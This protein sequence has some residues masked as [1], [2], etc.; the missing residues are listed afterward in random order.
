MKLLKGKKIAEKILKN[1]RKSIKKSRIKPALAVI[2][3]G[4]DLA[5]ELYV[6]LKK[7]AAKRVGIK[8]S[9]FRFSAGAKENAIIGKIK[10]L[11]NDNK[12]SG[13][14]V[15]LPLPKK[16][17]TQ[18]I[19][20]LISFSKDVD[21]FHPENLK[22]FMAGKAKIFP[23]FPTAILEMIKASE[24]RLR[25]KSA[26]VAANSERFGEI[27]KKMMEREKIKAQYM[28]RK[29]LKGNLPKLKKADILFS[30]LGVPGV[31]KGD[32]IKTG[33]I[34]IDGGITRR[35]KKVLGDV[36]FESVKNKASY[37]SP[38]PGGVGPVTVA[39]LL[40]NVWLAA[41]TQK[42]KN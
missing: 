30:A 12:I 31:V 32:M 9:V 4:N 5:S 38:V 2:L 6:N 11:N 36:D 1:I 40:R 7:K 42:H 27:M 14:I 39:C 33:A 26:I 29:N 16:L 25:G 10:K 34:I 35:G 15:Q 22:L 37:I 18:K 19:I 17:D 28:L 13:I 8:F 23:V 3:V 41:R 20:N 24:V 21:G